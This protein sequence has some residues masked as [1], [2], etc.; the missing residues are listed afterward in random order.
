MASTY[1]PIIEPSDIEEA[2]RATLQRWLDTMLGEVERQS[3]T[4]WGLREI[5]RPR[6]WHMVTNYRAS[7]ADRR[8]PCVAIE[9]GPIARSYT[10]DGLVNKEVGLDLI[11]IT[12]GQDR[13]KTRETLSALVT[14]IELVLEKHGDLDGFAAWTLV[15][16]IE[17]DVIQ[18]EKAK[19]VAGARIP[20]VVGVNATLSK[21]GG[22]AEPDPPEV[23]LPPDSPEYPDH[24]ETNIA[25]AYKEA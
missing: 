8:L 10:G 5:Q 20:I 23:D 6:T 11:V 15:G 17:P 25:V 3:G 13:E 12:K 14:G 21:R 22:P 7:A 1:G 18:A 19:T 2:V 9:V 4:R 16:D 24:T